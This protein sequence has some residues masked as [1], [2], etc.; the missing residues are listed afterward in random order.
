MALWGLASV[1]RSPGVTTLALATGGNWPAA[2]RA[3]VA[4]LDPS[5][6]D[7]ALRFG[8]PPSPD[9]GTLAAE[10]RPG[11]AV[12]GGSSLLLDHCQRLPGGLEVLI[13]P[14]SPGMARMPLDVLSNTLVTLAGHAGVDM[15]LDCGHLESASHRTS[16]AEGG[17]TGTVTAVERGPAVAGRTA[18]AR[19]LEQC[20]QV[21]LVTRPAWTDLVHVDQWKAGLEYLQVPVALVLTGRGRFGAREVESALGLEVLAVVPEDH[22]GAAVVAGERNARRPGGL[23]LMRAAR[24]LATALVGR[25]PVPID[26]TATEGDLPE[27]SSPFA[28]VHRA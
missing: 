6:G 3:V 21:V 9:I 20:D 16:A 19:L 5:G 25:L 27:P 1:R 4:E 2:R 11:A 28:G 8:L 14:P 26:V 13:A 7:I 22:I 17:S 12:S 15:L 10:L 23:P 24:E 18:V